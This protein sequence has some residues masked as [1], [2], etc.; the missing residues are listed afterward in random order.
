MKQRSCCTGTLLDPHDATLLLAY[1]TGGV[2]LP[3]ASGE[4]LPTASR[5]T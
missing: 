1:I 5:V 4:K 3:D 2:V